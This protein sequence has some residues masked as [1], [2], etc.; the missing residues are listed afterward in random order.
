M[1]RRLGLMALMLAIS[2]CAAAEPR[3]SSTMAGSPP[4][5]TRAAAY[6]DHLH[7][8]GFN[9]S[10]L[11]LVDGTEVV[12]DGFGLARR[13]PEIPFGV[14]TVVPIGS[15]TKMFTAA[16]VLA[17]ADAGELRTTDT[18]ADFFP[19]APPD[20]ADITVQQLLEHRSGLPEYSGED[21]D[22]LT[23]DDF[24]EFTL[25]A[26]LAF[27]PGADQAYSN[28]GYS[29]LAAIVEQASGRDLESFL[30]DR[31]FGPAG[32]D[33]T[34]LAHV[35]WRDVELAHAYGRNDRDLGTMLDLPR[36]GDR[37]TWNLHGNGG[38]LSTPHDMLRWSTALD[39]PRIVPPGVRD[40]LLALFGAPGGPGIGLA[41]GDGVSEAMVVRLHSGIFVFVANNTGGRVAGGIAD[42]LAAMARGEPIDERPTSLP[43]IARGDT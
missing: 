43:S 14:D 20:K 18:L 38:L 11:V 24:I 32:M 9:G 29:M 30:A 17:M 16:A 13:Q 35:D 5:D 28:V 10:A 21:V 15:I 1:M 19:G 37:L 3:G 8:L 39:D 4:L 31:F 26:P 40:P 33:R 2:G 12:A 23:Y 34:G 7:G 6:L 27:E 41:G 36:D 25:A 42:R 22:L